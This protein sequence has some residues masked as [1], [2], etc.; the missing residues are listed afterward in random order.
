MCLQYKTSAKIHIHMFSV[1]QFVKL[2]RN[3]PKEKEATQSQNSKRIPGFKETEG[4]GGDKDLET[5][6]F[7]EERRGSRSFSGIRAPSPPREA[8]A[9]PAQM[10]RLKSGRPHSLTKKGNDGRKTRARARDQV[11][12]G[13][14]QSSPGT[15]SKRPATA[16]RSQLCPSELSP[17][18]R[19]T[20]APPYLPSP[21]PGHP[22][23]QPSGWGSRSRALP[24]APLPP[25]AP[26][27]APSLP[28]QRR[29]REPGKSQPLRLPAQAG[30]PQPA[31]GQPLPGRGVHSR[32]AG[33]LSPP[34][35][36]AP[37]VPTAAHL[38][39]AAREGRGPGVAL[40]SAGLVSPP[41][42]RVAAPR[43]ARSA[44]LL[45]GASA[46]G[47]WRLSGRQAGRALSSPGRSEAAAAAAGG[48][49]L[50]DGR[51]DSFTGWPTLWKKQN[52]NAFFSPLFL[53]WSI[54]MELTLTGS[55]ESPEDNSRHSSV[56][57]C[58]KATR[59]GHCENGAS[60][61]QNV[62]GN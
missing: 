26:S 42:V 11:T 22:P 55:P 18:S 30:C 32:P 51:L 12:F 29:H 40:A 14:E 25:S 5:V 15:L 21:R 19:V 2:H 46:A 53:F 24:A 4:R 20:S 45:R 43:S 61:N 1:L 34:R 50:R 9:V 60:E 27:R 36:P 3:I 8:A 38:A 17:S 54:Q 37:G 57:T 44:A 62:L 10:N 33:D 52:R 47:G 7:L 23:Q 13:V 58:K 41:P 39:L 28:P 59:A 6:T 56:V 48:G 31:K 16:G 35:L 49:F